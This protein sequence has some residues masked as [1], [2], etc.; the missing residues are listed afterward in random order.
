MARLPRY[1]P[2]GIP[3]HVIQRGNN[4]S[5]CFAS[6]EDMAVYAHYLSEA[7]CKFGL[8]IHG[9][10]F[11]TNHVHLLVTPVSGQAAFAKAWAQG[12]LSNMEFLL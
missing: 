11:M 8:L 2:S 12:G 7:A 9:W 4:R 1:C 5:V 6:D 3:Q 10:G